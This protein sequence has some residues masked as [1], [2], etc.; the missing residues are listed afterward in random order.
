MDYRLL[1]NVR[2]ER[3]R[4]QEES[5]CSQDDFFVLV[6]SGE[7]SVQRER[8]SFSVH[9]GEGFFFQHGIRYQRKI[10]KPA[11]LHVFRYCADA[12]LFKS[13][14]VTFADTQRV[15]STAGMLSQLNETVFQTDFFYRI[16]LFSDIV[17]QY[18]IENRLLA[19]RA[20]E[21]DLLM[22]KEVA[23]IRKKIAKLTSVE[24][25]ARKAGLSYVQYLRR[26]R[27]FTGM[28]PTEY[29]AAIRLQKAKNLLEQTDLM[30]KEVAPLCGFENEYYFCNFFKKHVSVSPSAYRKLVK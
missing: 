27:A 8:H 12:P 11:I 20:V 13:E 21:T 5:F 14:H 30:I 9:P 16:H 1:A 4:F 26:F 28:Q 17:T 6:E 3:E 19:H 25:L 29:I 15:L 7:F 18:A 10:T 23:A 22:Q 2:A 24:Q